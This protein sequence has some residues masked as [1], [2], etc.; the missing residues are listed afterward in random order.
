MFCVN[1]VDAASTKSDR[2][3]HAVLVLARA[4]TAKSLEGLVHVP[5]STLK[6]SGVSQADRQI[7][8]EMKKASAGAKSG[9]DVGPLLERLGKHVGAAS[10]G[11]RAASTLR[12][13]GGGNAVRV[14]LKGLLAF[15]RGGSSQLYGS[16]APTHDD[17]GVSLCLERQASLKIVETTLHVPQEAPELEEEKSD[18]AAIDLS[19]GLGTSGIVDF[20]RIHESAHDVLLAL[21]HEAVTAFAS[22]HSV[23]AWQRAVSAIDL[24]CA[25]A[26]KQTG[27]PLPWSRRPLQRIY[28]VVLKMVGVQ[29]GAIP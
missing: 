16:D 26:T 11:A 10:A 22:D 8:A 25:E 5:L 3:D 23:S 28:D 4:P 17:A 9:E 6:G 27:R 7:V 29:C 1:A 24:A 21:L 12:V 13:S 14:L 19:Q 2:H 15:F 20:H 18:A